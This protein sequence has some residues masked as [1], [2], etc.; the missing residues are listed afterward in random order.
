LTVHGVL[1][2]IYRPHSFQIFQVLEVLLFRRLKTAKKYLIQDIAISPQLGH[3][4]CVFRANEQATTSSTVR[5]LWIEKAKIRRIP[6]FS[7][8]WEIDY[9]ETAPSA[10]RLQQRWGWPMTRG[11]NSDLST[12]HGE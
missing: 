3:V 6:E 10:R 7:E 12:W 8:V 2:V 9:P 11:F 1:L 5:G 4:M